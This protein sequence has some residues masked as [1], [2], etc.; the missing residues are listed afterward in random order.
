MRS[1]ESRRAKFGFLGK[2]PEK[3]SAVDFEMADY[4]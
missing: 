2:Y 3:I 1:L 4:T